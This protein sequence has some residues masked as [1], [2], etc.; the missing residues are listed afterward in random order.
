MEIMLKSDSR[1]NKS[2]KKINVPDVDFEDLNPEEVSLDVLP[3]KYVFAK[4]T[5]T[6]QMIQKLFTQGNKSKRFV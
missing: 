6:R 2:K 1:I 3:S 5:A 4:V